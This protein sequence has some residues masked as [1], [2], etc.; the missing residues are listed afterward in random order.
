MHNQKSMEC[1]ICK[2]H[3]QPLIQRMKLHIISPKAELG[4]VHMKFLEP[5]HFE[6]VNFLQDV[7]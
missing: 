1:H 6:K 2:I 3:Q 7:P 4:H 5:P